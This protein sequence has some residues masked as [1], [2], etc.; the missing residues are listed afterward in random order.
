MILKINCY[1]FLIVIFTD[2]QER[3]VNKTFGICT[4]ILGFC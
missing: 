2:F 1:F 3:S 4:R